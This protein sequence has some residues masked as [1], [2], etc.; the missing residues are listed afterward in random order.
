MSESLIAGFLTVLAQCEGVKYL[1]TKDVTAL[2]KVHN[3][4][5]VCF[6]ITFK[7]LF[8]TF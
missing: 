5:L 7:M 3:K 6:F 2:S 4:N 8:N 1:E